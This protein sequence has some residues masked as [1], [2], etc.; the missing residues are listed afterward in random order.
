MDITRLDEIKKRCFAKVI[1]L[2]EKDGIK[3]PLSKYYPIE[4]ISFW[5]VLTQDY[6]FCKYLFGVRYKDHIH[7]IIDAYYDYGWDGVCDYLEE[8]L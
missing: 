7:H 5:A 6:E 3:N 8:F 2:M 1:L 4:G